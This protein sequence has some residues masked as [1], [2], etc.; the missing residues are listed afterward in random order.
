MTRAWPS[1]AE[2]W[3]TA[4]L[5]RGEGK[6]RKCG[7]LARARHGCAKSTNP[8]I[9]GASAAVLQ[10]WRALK[11]STT[12]ITRCLKRLWGG[13]KIAPG[14]ISF[15]QIDF[16][17]VFDLGTAYSYRKIHLF[18]SPFSCPPQ[19]S[20]KAHASVQPIFRFDLCRVKGIAFFF[21]QRII[22][23]MEGCA[24]IWLKFPVPRLN[25][26]HQPVFE[27]KG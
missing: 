20:P 21:K 27:I 2:R 1:R 15:C 24:S 12:L 23:D 6:R 10:S 26:K 13:H 14:V 4:P 17:V 11:D 9:L 19:S 7:P 25:Y 8:I 16:S 18:F 3:K 5:K 22:W